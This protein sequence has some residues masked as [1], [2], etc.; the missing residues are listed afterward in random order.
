MTDNEERW[1]G[2][3]ICVSG[4]I[5]CRLNSL[6]DEQ[7]LSELYMCQFKR[8]TCVVGVCDWGCWCHIDLYKDYVIYKDFNVDEVL[9]FWSANL[10]L[11]F[12]GCVSS[13]FYSTVIYACAFS[14]ASALY[15][16]KYVI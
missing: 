5:F 3:I 15:L 16:I 9:C 11:V 4:S 13:A 1:M 6:F 2:C 14:H 10:V 7:H 8:K 12:P